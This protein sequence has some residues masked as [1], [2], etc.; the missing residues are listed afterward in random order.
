[1]I[2]RKRG[3]RL[4]PVTKTEVVKRLLEMAPVK[5]GNSDKA[6]LVFFDLR[7]PFCARLFKEAEETLVEM[8]RRGV[9]T[10]AMCDYVVH[11]DAEPLHRKLR[12]TAEDER[13]KF[14]AEAFSGKK[15]EVGD[16][17]E[18]NLREC[19]RLAEEVGVYGT[20]TIIFYN[21]A[22]GRGYIHFGYMSP[23]EV[24]EAISAL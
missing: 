21:F 23:S 14:I 20:P 18:G 19:E 11:K 9:I 12:C 22:K 24:L 5:I 3:P 1:M 4:T 8:A 16:C 17:P 15:V 10:L 13:L 6:V 7:C 2:F